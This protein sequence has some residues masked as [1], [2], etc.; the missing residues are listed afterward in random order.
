[1]RTA[2]THARANPFPGLRPFRSDE[3]HLFFGR[4]EQT[5][6]LL[7]RLRMGRFLAV[8]GTSGS[9][10]SSL[11][12]AGMIA[13][14]HGGT[15]TQAGSSWEVMILRPGGSPIENLA[16]A[17]VDADLYDAEDPSTLPRLLATLNRSRFGLVEAMKQSELFEPGTNLLVVVDQFEELFRFRQQGVDS[18]ETAAAFVNLLLTAGEQAECPIYVTITMRSDY[19]G[20]CS[21]IPGLAEAVNEGEY[22]IPRLMRDQKRD[23]IEK[24]IGVGGAKIAPML[25]QRLL[26]E[27]GDDPDQ[28]PVL[29]HA[30]MRMWDAWSLGG[31]RN[32]P[33]DAADFEATGGLS[34]A[35][36][37][38]AD[39]IYDALPDDRHRSACE[40]IFKTLT[41]KGEDNRGIRRP[42]RLSQLQAIADTDRDTILTVIDAYRGSGVTFLMPGTEA[43]LRDRT[44]LDLSHE[45]LMRGWQRLRGWVEEEAQSARIFRRLLDTARLWGDRKAGLFRDPDLQIA[46]SWRDEE[47]PNAAWADQYGGDFGDAIRFLEASHAEVEAE[48]QA[49]ESSRQRE[50]DQARQLAEAQQLRLEHQQR[51]ARKLHKMIA[52]L[53]AVA[54]VAGLAFVAALVNNRRANTLAEAAKRNEAQARKSEEATASALAVVG[55]QKRAVESSLAKAEKAE[56]DGRKLLYT[57]DMRLAPFVW[58]D[59]RSTAE[60]LRVLLAKHVPNP[61]DAKQKSAAN[62]PDLRG[63][64]W[65]YYQ[66]LFEHGASVFSGHPV[67]V[68]GGA[69]APDGTLVTLDQNGQVRRWDLDSQDEDDASRRDLP[70]G[71]VAESRALSTDG[72]RAALVEDNKV[73]VFDTSSGVETFQLDSPKDAN[74]PRNLI[75]SQNGDSLVIVDATVRWVNASNGDVIATWNQSFDRIESLALSADGLTLAVVGNA[76]MGNRFSVFRLDPTG[77]T[78]SRIAS[79]IYCGGTV[80]ASACTPNGQLLAVGSMLS[81]NLGVFDTSTGRLIAQHGA[82]HA[83]TITSMAFSGDGERL[84][85]ADAEGIIKLWSG[86]RKLNAKSSAQLTLKGHQGEIKAVGFSID[87]KRLVSSSADKTARVWDLANAGAAIQPLERGGPSD[88][89]RISPDGQLIAATIG[90]SIRLW[91]ATTGRLVRELPP[92]DKGRI[93]A[94][95]FSP[96][97]VRVLAV[98]IRGENQVA[99][100]ALWDIDAGTELARLPI[101]TDATPLP[102]SIASR[103]PAALAFSPDGKYLVAAYGFTN[104]LSDDSFN[105]P[106]DVW[107]VAAGKRIRGLKG[108]TNY[109]VSLEFSRDG[110]RLAS[111]GRDGK[112]ILWSTETWKA[113]QTLQNPDEGTLY[114][115][116]GM[117]GSVSFSPDGAT[118]AMASREGN[119]HLWDVESGQLLDSLKGHSNAVQ[120][121]AFSPDGRTLAS[122]SSDQTVRLWNVETRR[123]LMQLNSGS[124][125]LGQ[126]LTLAFS[127]NGKHLLTGGQTAAFWSAETI[128]WNDPDRAVGA[129][130]KLLKSNADFRSRIRMLSENLRLH[131]ALAKLDPKEPHVQ[132]ALAATQANWNASRKAWPEAVAA[133]DRLKAADPTGPEAW[134]RTPGLLRLAMALTQQDRPREAAALLAGGARRRT[135]DGLPSVANDVALG[136]ESSVEDD[137]VRVVELLP[138]SPAAKSR[139]APGDV[140][141]KINDTD[142]NE[143]T[144]PKFSQLAS[145]DA[146]TKVRL[147]VRHAGS[148]RPEAIELTLERFPNDPATGD[149]LYPLRTAIDERLAKEPRDARLLELRAEL[150]GQWSDAKA[151]VDDYSAAIEAIPEGPPETNSADL[152]RLYRRRGDANLSLKHWREA[153]DD[154]ARVVTDATTDGTL[155]TDQA[156]ALGAA[157]LESRDWTVLR[158]A[159]IRSRG[160]ATLKLQD[161][162]SILASGPNVSGDVYTISG[163]GDLD[164]IAA[165]RL[166]VLPDPSLPHNGPGRHSTGNF[167]LGAFRLYETPGDDA[168]PPKPLAFESAWA[169]FEYLAGDAT[170]AGTI[171][172]T[173][174]Q[175]WHVW[176]HFGEANEAVFFLKG[177]A[178]ELKGRPLTIELR[179]NEF[180][181]GINLGRFRLSV[182]GERLPF[183]E[184]QKRFGLPKFADPWQKLAAAYRLEGD[185]QA[186]DKLVDR[187]PRAAGP[188]GELFTQGKNEDKSWP[189]AIALY[190]K[191]I[192]AERTDVDLLSKRALAYEALKDWDAAAADWTRAAAG[193]RDEAKLM[194]DFARRL[195]AGGK[196]ALARRQ[197]EKAQALDERSLEADPGNDVVAGELAQLLLDRSVP[198]GPEWVVL[199]PADTKTE[200]GSKL[201]LEDDGSILVET[202]PKTPPGTVRWEPGPLSVQAL[203]VE[204]SPHQDI[205]KDG[206]PFFS[207]Y[208]V[209]AASMA[210]PQSKGLRGRFVRL[211]LPGDNKQFPR[212]SSEKP[213]EKMINLAE[214]QVFQGK[215]NIAMGKKATMSSIYGNGNPR[216]AADGAVDGKTVGNDESASNRYAHTD[217][218]KDPW[219]EVDLGSEQAID[220]MVVWNRSDVKYHSRMNHFR[221]RVLDSSREVVFEQVVDA[222]PTPSRDIAP[223]VSLAESNPAAAGKHRP[224]LIAM[225]APARDEAPRRYRVSAAASLEE[226]SPDDDRNK[227][228]SGAE[229][230][231]LRL[232]VAYAANGLYDQSLAYFHTA[233]ERADGY[234]ARRPILKFAARFDEIITP[235]IRQNPDDAPMQLALA[236]ELAGRGKRRLGQEQPAKA[237][238]ELEK[239]RAILT[240]LREAAADPH[241][242]VLTPAKMTSE[243]GTTFSKLDD[244]SIL[245]GGKLSPKDVYTLEFRDLPATIAGL[246]LEAL[247]DSSLQGN[248]PG[249]KDGN[250]A[251]S[252]AKVELELPTNPGVRLERKLARASGDY[253]QNSDS[254]A[255]SG[256]FDASGAID[257]EDRSFWAIHP[258]MGRPHE[259]VFEL[260]EPVKGTKGA[261]LRLT[262][263]FKSQYDGVLLGRFRLSAPADE[264]GF[265]TLQ[266]RNDLKDAEVVDLSIALAKAHSQQGHTAE[267]VAQLMEAIPFASDRASKARI[268]TEAATQ[269]GLLEKLTERRAEDGTFQAGLARHFASE[270]R[271]VLAA[272]AR[273]RARVSLE[274]E[275]AR[276]PGD[277]GLTAE[278]ADLLLIDTGAWTILKPFA[279]KSDAGLTFT[280]QADQSIFVS[281]NYQVKDDYTVDFRDVPKGV[282]TIRLEALQDERLPGGGPGTFN[283]LFVL[284]E[285][286][287]FSLDA[288]ESSDAV[289]I[290]LRSA[291]ATF[292]ERPAQMSLEPGE[293]GWSIF[294]GAG[295]SHTAYFYRGDDA[296]DLPSDRLRIL[297]D[298]SHIPWSKTAAILGCFRLS[299]STDPAMFKKAKQRVAPMRISDPWL[300]LA[301]AY[302]E[303]GEDNIAL[304]RF[305]TAL[306]SATSEEAR[307]PIFEVVQNYPKVRVHAPRQNSFVR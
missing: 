102:M 118:L 228:I 81:G 234:E 171:D 30:L 101:A 261:A 262:L 63:F 232:A 114:T 19:L 91:D 225:P 276:S 75:F 33:I 26:N 121:V 28:L 192:T 15:M 203:R 164:K 14:L 216:L 277:Y 214:F 236:R 290:P 255:V 73:R 264:Q 59:G 108:H 278:L 120:A 226:L 272:A 4:E 294:G 132:A 298:F 1:M 98:G 207:E 181:E 82:A 282:R 286:H 66:H 135:Q 130:R 62:K 152:Q 237:Q 55:S 227:H 107:D 140:I 244:G 49:R 87:E 219:W 134:L 303:N 136:F 99:Y 25:V 67:P 231:T 44:V 260:A 240:R 241:W 40:K 93:T 279:M 48:E 38:H 299:V 174:K 142:L 200:E 129:L 104:I 235:L 206:A 39:E 109:C 185:Q 212:P 182:S 56:E 71:P 307:K 189:R 37:N 221:V 29:Q 125:V 257:A 36:S 92:V 229:D 6:A 149:V 281:G 143:E 86:V 7:Q 90:Q 42:T 3:H 238:A 85:T 196:N 165:L 53:A 24:P 133:F 269:P 163:L 304:R 160:G 41:E 54:V 153:V 122:G 270:G 175:F 31:D 166:E 68:C 144:I 271:P 287:A 45:S 106:L 95:A 254:R 199:K 34:A 247:T 250:F 43:E 167:Q 230:V 301:A 179:F 288:N 157:M 96:T 70:G 74:H 224:L 291:C 139:L 170:V 218:E 146:G 23:A 253:V 188:I 205:P 252:K 159:E 208:Q 115:R 268:I 10:K 197:F 274:S 97:D 141:L 213:D 61:V 124:V 293:F 83:S 110:T 16:R 195:A 242:T 187:H 27:V 51:A 137:R 105:N 155:L 126:L 215:R 222:A 128:L 245:A 177:T 266:A 112:A 198:A 300:R 47:G 173:R 217:S 11:V 111:G 176:G 296:Q 248:G 251:L 180:A 162:G 80:H 209:I 17:F 117:V 32:R 302:A 292:E 72:R 20:D 280:A 275:L 127:P 297:L 194:C 64:E 50:L 158:P 123:E 289:P 273:A 35:L 283:G 78:I 8:V 306:E 223:S 2:I 116:R 156:T 183:D 119:I 259:A 211:D 138:G 113:T 220:R 184:K 84:A 100:V 239:S 18:E 256:L 243:G 22:L 79:D 168:T 5:A 13:E 150:A 65:D 9:G 76:P 60:Q 201:T 267:A 69:F 265:R 191:G 103:V 233:L 169:S 305:N 57:T 131:E 147:S 148:D 285:F 186:I 210:T 249:R 89:A 161:D 94:V 246:R 193:N 190:S 46:L 145:G 204:T 178:T 154:Y 172:E 284:S 58:S 151:Q 21:E 12:R 202:V 88:A 258:M 263:E 295:Q 77:R 52:G